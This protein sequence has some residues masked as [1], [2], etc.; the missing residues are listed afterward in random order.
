MRCLG[1][2]VIGGVVLVVLAA[3]GLA[4]AG[5]VQVPI[6]SAALGMDKPL[7]LGA[8]TPDAT[9]YA[10]FSWEHG[11]IHTTPDGNDTRSSEHQFSGSYTLNELVPEAV[12]N[13]T[14][15]LQGTSATI[16]GA[17]ANVH[18]SWAEASAFVDASP[19]GCPISGPVHVSFSLEVTGPRGIAVSLDRVELGRVG[20]PADVIATAEDAI[21]GYLATRLPQIEGLEIEKLT[22]T[23]AGIQYQ[24]GC[25][26]RSGRAR[27][28]GDSC[29]GSARGPRGIPEGSDAPPHPP[30]TDR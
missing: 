27:R 20:L 28:C 4:C 1:R 22:L 7:D 26:T 13:A 16:R 10:A 8:D 21:N 17:S 11:L 25:R 15:T 3:G 30:V 18:G 23:E 19:W 29:P 6:L 12:I 24:E 5:V 14:R 2:A 9:A